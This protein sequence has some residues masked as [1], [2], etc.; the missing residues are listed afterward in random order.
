MLR[1]LLQ[2][3]TVLVCM[4]I[5]IS[6]VGVHWGDAFDGFV[7]S[8]SLFKSGAL[9]TCKWSYTRIYAPVSLHIIA[10]GIVGATVMP[11]SIF[12]GSALATQDRT[13]YTDKLTRI[14]TTDSDATMAPS[15]F[16]FAFPRPSDLVHRLK[17]GIRKTFRIIP[18]EEFPTDPKTHAERENRDYGFVRAHIYHGMID[19]AVSLLGIAVVI[20]ALYV[21]VTARIPPY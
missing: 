9:Y 17:S 6:Q 10:V 8:S 3:F 12:L 1:R 15:T 5:I 2:V 20:N 14:D 21:R 18:I 16:R 13:G 19:I 4:A 7:P 11:H